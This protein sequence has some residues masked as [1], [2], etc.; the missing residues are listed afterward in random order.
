MF[1]LIVENIIACLLIAFLI[2]SLLMVVASLLPKLIAYTFEYNIIHIIILFVV[3]IILFIQVL[4]MVGAGYAKGYVSEAEKGMISTKE[5]INEMPDEIVEY[6]NSY[7]VD[8]GQVQNQADQLL[9]P[10]RDYLNSYMLKRVIWILVIYSLLIIFLVYQANLA[11]K[12]KNPSRGHQH[13]RR[14]YDY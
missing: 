11:S 9:K 13:R 1:Y 6:A 10:I 14:Y 2:T 5:F 4:L 7:V 3:G 12:R 8:T